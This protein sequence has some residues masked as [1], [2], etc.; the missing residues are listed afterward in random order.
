MTFNIPVKS[1]PSGDYLDLT[2]SLPDDS[3]GLVLCYNK[4]S[5]LVPL[6]ITA[7]KRVYVRELEQL[8]ADDPEIAEI[9]VIPITAFVNPAKL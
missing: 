3:M 5:G 1:S 8:A 4:G 2:S 7:A 9:T 6:R